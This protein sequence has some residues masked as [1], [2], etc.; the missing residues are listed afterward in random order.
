VALLGAND[1]TYIWNPGDGSDTVEGQAGTDTL[2]FNGANVAENI[3]ISANGARVR[4]TRDVANITR[5]STTP[6][7]SP[8]C[9]GGADNVTVNDPSTGVELV[10]IDLQANGGGG[11]GGLI[12]WPSTAPLVPIDH[13]F[14]G[15]TLWMVWLQS[16]I[17]QR[18]PTT[19]AD[20]RT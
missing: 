16:I 11:D 17:G 12:R 2:I 3:A 9:P 20:Q 19:I 7:G 15:R 8:P 4:L 18:A 10:S 1:D 14:R 5:T 13:G 6:S